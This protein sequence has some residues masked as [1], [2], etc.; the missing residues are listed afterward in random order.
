MTWKTI[1]D[2]PEPGE[3]IIV[4]AWEFGCRP[5]LFFARMWK[6]SLEDQPMKWYLAPELYLLDRPRPIGSQVRFWMAIPQIEP[7][8]A[9]LL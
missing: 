7:E 1:D 3:L 9:K 2:P 4:A 5:M 8:Q 6:S